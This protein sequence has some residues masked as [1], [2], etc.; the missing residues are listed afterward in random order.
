MTTKSRIGIYQKRKRSEFK[1]FG[2]HADRHVSQISVKDTV[3]TIN[4]FKTNV[5]EPSKIFP[6]ENYRISNGHLKKIFIKLKIDKHSLKLKYTN[7]AD[8]INFDSSLRLCYPKLIDLLKK[9]VAGSCG[10]QIYLK[11]MNYVAMSILSDDL[12][13]F[14]RIYAIWFSIFILR[15]W[16]IYIFQTKRNFH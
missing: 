8:K 14:Q 3:H 9:H 13:I 2:F 15:F 5:F 12:T 16:R 11:I 10:T 1:F 4:N 7:V 6:L